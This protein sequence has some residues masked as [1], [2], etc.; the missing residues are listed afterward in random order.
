MP[1][2]TITELNRRLTAE[3]KDFQEVMEQARRVSQGGETYA[4]RLLY[5]HLCM[6]VVCHH[7]GICPDMDVMPDFLIYMS[8]SGQ[9]STMMS[10]NTSFLVIRAHL[11]VPFA[12]QQLMLDRRLLLVWPVRQFLRMSQRMT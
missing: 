9:Q 4:C 2:V 1:K 8:V 6:L 12:G 7:F 3:P 10:C 11:A 5:I